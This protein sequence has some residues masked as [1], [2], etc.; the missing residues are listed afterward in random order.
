MRIASKTKTQVYIAL[1]IAVELVLAMTP[2]GFIPIGFIRATTIHIPVIIGAI[3]FGPV[4]GMLL[5]GIFGLTSIVVNTFEPNVT[6]F[7]FSPFYG[8]GE[9]HGNF[10]SLI[11]AMVPRIMIGVTAYYAFRWTYKRDKK[12]VV[13][14]VAAGLVG[15][16]TNTLLVMLGI[17]VFFGQ[18]Y[19][20]AK[21]IPYEALFVF[22]IGIIGT[23]GVVEAIVAG[24]LTLFVAKP[25]IKVAKLNVLDINN[26]FK[27]EN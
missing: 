13:S 19:A 23:N 12:K 10:W 24:L 7:V 20:L 2:I 26:T 27:Q 5:G 17:Y 18:S 11:I 4:V 21:D 8:I 1:L 15:S 6:S 22:I 3:L 16:L 25:L 9:F 14:F